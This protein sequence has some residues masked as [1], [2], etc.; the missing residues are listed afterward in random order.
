M[1][2]KRDKNECFKNK[3]FLKIEHNLYS[4][5]LKNKI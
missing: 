5:D 1:R 4:V 2:V 3:C